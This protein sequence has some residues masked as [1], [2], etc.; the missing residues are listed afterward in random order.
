M[1]QLHGNLTGLS[2]DAA[3]SLLA[4]ARRAFRDVFTT[5]GQSLSE[6]SP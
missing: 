4:R 1:Q 5:L 3:K 6:V 2:A